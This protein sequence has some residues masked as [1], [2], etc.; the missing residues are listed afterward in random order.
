MLMILNIHKKKLC[1]NSCNVSFTSE[2]NLGDGV[3][4]E[5]INKEY[6]YTEFNDFKHN[7]SLP[8]C[9]DLLLAYIK[10]LIRDQKPVGNKKTS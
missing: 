5:M 6:E 10:R 7:P 8:D 2:I 4:Q 9:I 3:P 1:Y